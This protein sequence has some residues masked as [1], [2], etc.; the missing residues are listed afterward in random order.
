MARQHA[1]VNA[2]GPTRG[3]RI[4]S[5]AGI[6]LGE[7]L[8]RYWA[9]M[10]T[11]VLGL[12]VLIP[13]LIPFLSYLGLDSI[14]K[15]LFFALHTICAQIPS[16]SFYLFG[17]QLGLCVRNPFRLRLDVCRGIGLCSQQKTPARS[18]LVGM[19]PHDPADGPGRRDSDVRLARKHLGTAHDHR[20]PVWRRERL[21]C[22]SPH[23]E[24]PSLNFP[25]SPLA[26]IGRQGWIASHLVVPPALPVE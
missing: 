20:H 23:S 6:W 2:T 25:G 8:L 15:P 1:Q 5:Q 18:T 13:L 14:A 12:I 9:H 3:L 26:C 22:A 11:A 24:A 16:H 7:L 4:I 17:H 10:V 21:V 19:G